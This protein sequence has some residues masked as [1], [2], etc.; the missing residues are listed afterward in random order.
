L[1]DFGAAS[2]FNENVLIPMNLEFSSL[3]RLLGSLGSPLADLESLVYVLCALS[4]QKLPWA[5][6]A[7][8]GNM[9]MCIGER[10]QVLHTPET[11]VALGG[12]PE[13]LQDFAIVALKAAD[14]GQAFWEWLGYWVDALRK[15]GLA[16]NGNPH[17]VMVSRSLSLPFIV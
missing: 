9:V 5:D 6:A 17:G 11:L 4:G 12:L 2:R 15:K 14:Q 10:G 13:I 3:S 7:K 1:Y 8:E 16:S